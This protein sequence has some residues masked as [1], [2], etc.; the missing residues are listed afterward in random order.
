MRLVNGT[1]D[2]NGRLEVCINGQWGSVCERYFDDVD[3]QVVCKELGFPANS[4][5]KCTNYF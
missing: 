3:A 2:W 1:E 4:K 5:K